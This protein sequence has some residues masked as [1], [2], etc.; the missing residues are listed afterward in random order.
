MTIITV[1]I[2]VMIIVIVGMYS[3]LEG[4]GYWFK[5]GLVVSCGFVCNCMKD[6]AVVIV[7]FCLPPCGDEPGCRVSGGWG[8]FKHFIVGLH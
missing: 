5:V 1:S 4:G 2:S 8:L 6:F 3:I 7:G